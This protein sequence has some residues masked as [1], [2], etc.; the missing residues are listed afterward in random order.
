MSSLVPLALLSLFLGQT[1]SPDSATLKQAAIFVGGLTACAVIA[2]QIL[3]AMQGF[4]KLRGADPAEDRRYVSRPEH[5]AL[6]DVV[7]SLKGEFQGLSRTITNEFS[8]LNRSIGVLEGM[9]TAMNG[10][11]KE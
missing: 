7:I 11:S 3:G 4:K 9:L 2:N 5:E 6:K 10:R 1:P 8:E